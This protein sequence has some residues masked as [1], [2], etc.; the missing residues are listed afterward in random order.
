MA[1]PFFE[2]YIFCFF[3]V[4]NNLLDHG[5]ES[6]GHLPNYPFPIDRYMLQWLIKNFG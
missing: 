5:S 6:G 2:I 1:I 4:K 3:L